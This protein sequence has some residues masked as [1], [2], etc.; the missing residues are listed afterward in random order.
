MTPSREAGC[1]HRG[2]D[3]DR[4]NRIPIYPGRLASIPP[5]LQRDEPEQGSRSYPQGHIMSLYPNVNERR[6]VPLVQNLL[7][8][9]SVTHPN[10]R[11][12]RTTLQLPPSH[13]DWS[14]S[15]PIP[16]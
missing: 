14:P 12:V 11:V 15:P 5:P 9:L 1:F 16:L 3:L 7:M 6:R 2:E 10:S 13:D 4:T 8:S